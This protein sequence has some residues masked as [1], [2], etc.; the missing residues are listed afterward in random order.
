M[1]KKDKL[2]ENELYKK[3]INL[4]TEIRKLNQEIRVID[5][6]LSLIQID[7]VA[8]EVN[9]N[10]KTTPRWRKWF[11]V[12]RSSKTKEFFAEP[13]PYDERK[14]SLS[15]PELMFLRSYKASRLEELNKEVHELSAKI[16]ED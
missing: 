11:K 4:N 8:D 15:E 7:R 6:T 14:I 12:T 1:G 5:E 10:T 3:A 13:N 9:N 2:A 16:S